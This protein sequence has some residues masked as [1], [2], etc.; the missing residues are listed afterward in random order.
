MTQHPD[1]VRWNGRYQNN[2]HYRQQGSASQL[3][4]D[5]AHLLPKSGVVLDAAAGV[6]V[7]ALYLAQRGFSVI[8]LDISEVGLQLLRQKANALKVAVETAVFDLT[9]PTFPA[10]CVDAIL[11]FRFLERAAFPAY[12]QALRPGGLLFFETF[13]H[14][15]AGSTPSY[16]LESGELHR[17]FADFKIIHSVETAVRG[18]RSGNMRPIAQLIARKQKNSHR[19]VLSAAKVEPRDKREKL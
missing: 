15:G 6:G 11:N 17:V 8:A 12:R 3:L 19:L 7:N 4:P 14:T 9:K 10:N 18:H 2:G 5:F 13:V 16:F 1:A